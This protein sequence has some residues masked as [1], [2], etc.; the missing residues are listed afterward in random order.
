MI[1]AAPAPL[2]TLP[3]SSFSLNKL[4]RNLQR[5]WVL[6]LLLIPPLAYL[7]IFNYIPMYGLQLAFREF[8]PAA[9]FYGGEWV[10]LQ[11]FIDF[12]ESYAFAEIILNTVLLSLYHIAINFFAP[13]MLAI[14]INEVNNQRFK[15]TVQMVTYA[16]YFIST[17]VLVAMMFQIFSPHIGIVNN[18]IKAMGGQTHNFMGESR[19]FR[20]LFVWSGIWQGTGYGSVIFIAAL[21]AIDPQLY[22]AATVDGASRIKKII[23]IDI[24]SIM[25]TMVVLLILNVGRLMNVGFEKTYLMQNQQNIAVSEVISTYVYKVGIIRTDFSFSTAVGFFNSA[26]NLALIVLV[27]QIARHLGESSLW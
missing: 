5:Y 6:Y 23:Y 8:D 19:Y 21:T 18:V 9:G 11:N 12:F 17:I 7:I 16:P 10:G 1:K 20:H 2:R 27:N 13:V 22:E 4:V 3:A 24:P 14:A 26:I 15:K 25:P